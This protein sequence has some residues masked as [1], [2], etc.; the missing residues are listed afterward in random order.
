MTGLADRLL[1]RLLPKTTA[2]ACVA[3][4]SWIQTHYCSGTCVWVKRW[5]K[6]YT[7]CSGSTACGYW[8]YTWV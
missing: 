7:T 8:T 3:Y 5:R 2:A 1:Q 6:C 4:E